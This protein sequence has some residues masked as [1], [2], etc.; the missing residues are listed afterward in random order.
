MKDE[1]VEEIKQKA[2]NGKLPCSFARRIAE[3]LA[4]SYKEVG[5]IADELSIKITNC[6]LGCF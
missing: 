2:I 5:R 1:I 3:E 4:V 6:E